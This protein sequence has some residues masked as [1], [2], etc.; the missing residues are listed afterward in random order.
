MVGEQ[1]FRDTRR[2]RPRGHGISGVAH[3]FD[4]PR[5]KEGSGSVTST[6]LSCEH[7]DVKIGAVSFRDTRYGLGGQ[8]DGEASH[9]GPP[10][11]DVRRT[12]LA[13]LIRRRGL[14]TRR[15]A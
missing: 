13:P 8:R 6:F 15:S 2:S 3:R 7:G 9:P 4:F 12:Q 10:A 1:A 11:R 14:P 5:G